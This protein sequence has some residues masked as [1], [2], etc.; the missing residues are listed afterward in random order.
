MPKKEKTYIVKFHPIEAII[1]EAKNELEAEEEA[2]SRFYNGE[3]E[4]EVKSVKEDKT[5]KNK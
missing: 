4:V 5:L 1:E 3:Y 2:I